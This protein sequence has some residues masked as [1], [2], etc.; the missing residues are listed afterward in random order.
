M[1]MKRHTVL[2][3][4]IIVVI[5]IVVFLIARYVPFGER[6]K[7]VGT[8]YQPEF[9]GRAMT[10]YSDG[11]CSDFGWP[12]TWEIRDGKLIITA[13]DGTSIARWNYSFSDNGRE[14]TLSGRGTWIKWG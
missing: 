4:G 11:S 14:L 7:F 2:L 9:Y 8:W 1:N 12:G 5:V 6:A 13:M 10:F 3:I